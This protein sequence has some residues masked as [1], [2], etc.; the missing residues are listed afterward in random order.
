MTVAE[1]HVPPRDAILTVEQVAEWMQISPEA[2]RHLNIPAIAVGR[3]K[4]QRWRYVAGMV[5][6]Y[7]QTK[8]E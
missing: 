2:V 7:L 6:D 4:R 8:A 3:G 1:L 5:L